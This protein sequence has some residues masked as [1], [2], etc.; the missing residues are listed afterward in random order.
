MRSFGSTLRFAGLPVAFS[1][2]L[3]AC[4]AP[5][6]Q[7]TTVDPA[8]ARRSA[9]VEPAETAYVARMDG[10]IPVPAIPLEKL[11]EA[12]RR[13]EVACQRL[14]AIVARPT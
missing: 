10:A 4:V 6:P 2:A 8:A 1:L 14:A 13:Q 3:S 12:Y 7:A 5:T 9:V 11:P